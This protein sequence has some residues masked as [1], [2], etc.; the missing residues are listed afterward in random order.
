MFL[1]DTSCIQLK[2]FPTQLFLNNRSI[3]WL[4]LSKELY[5]QGK[6][7]SSL[8]L[9]RLDQRRTAAARASNQVLIINSDCL[10]S[11]SASVAS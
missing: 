4:Y 1:E 5:C 2:F 9:E 10:G 3:C 6:V 7:K 8:P 11:D